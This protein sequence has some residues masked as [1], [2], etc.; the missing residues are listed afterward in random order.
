MCGELGRVTRTPPRPVPVAFRFSEFGVQVNTILLM[1]IGTSIST[2]H[3]CPPLT[4]ATLFSHSDTLLFLRDAR[5]PMGHL[6]TK[7]R[8]AWWRA[9]KT[10]GTLDQYSNVLTVYDMFHGDTPHTHVQPRR[11]PLPTATSMSF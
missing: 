4:V 8:A 11:A 6:R 5:L 10:N 2:S 7:E 3:K 1:R 9:D